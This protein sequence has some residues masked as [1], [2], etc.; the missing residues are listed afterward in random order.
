VADA[1]LFGMGVHSPGCVPDFE[2][3]ERPIAPF[4]KNPLPLFDNR[5]V[6]AGGQENYGRD[7]ALSHEVAAHGV[8]PP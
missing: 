3:V 6:W 8:F 2:A 1:D 7:V 5:L 4:A